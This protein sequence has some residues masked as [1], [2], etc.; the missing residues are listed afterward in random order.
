MYAKTSLK[1]VDLFE[2]EEIK[3]LTNTK[4]KGNSGNR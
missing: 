1:I 4:L 2:F 3:K